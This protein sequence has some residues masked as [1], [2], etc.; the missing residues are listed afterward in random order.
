LVNF[1]LALLKNLAQFG[2]RGFSGHDVL[3]KASELLVLGR[4]GF[5]FPADVRGHTLEMPKPQELALFKL[6]HFLEPLEQYIGRRIINPARLDCGK[7]RLGKLHTIGD[8]IKRK[9]HLSSPFS[10]YLS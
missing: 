10:E 6:E 7:I 5:E 3:D 9:P 8:L 1:N 2:H 4:G